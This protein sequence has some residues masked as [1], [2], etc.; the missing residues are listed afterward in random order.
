MSLIHGARAVISRLSKHDDRRSAWLKALL[1]RRG[2]N[3]T[4]VALANKTARI[5]CVM[6]TRKE[7]YTAA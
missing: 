2:F 1:A 4:I 5:A 3:R 6:L 7:E